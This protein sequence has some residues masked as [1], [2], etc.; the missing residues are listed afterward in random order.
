MGNVGVVVRRGKQCACWP[1]LELRPALIGVVKVM[2]VRKG[3]IRRVTHKQ[4]QLGERDGVP[5]VDC[6]GVERERAAVAPETLGP[7]R[8]ARPGYPPHVA[9]CVVTQNHSVR[10]VV[11]R[12]S[13]APWCEGGSGG[14]GRCEGWCGAVWCGAVWGG[15]RWGE[16]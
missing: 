10:E 2:K 1:H 14:V 7:A 13:L 3:S 11:M 4:Y 9:G 8:L 6:C 15:D 16:V 12:E 5:D